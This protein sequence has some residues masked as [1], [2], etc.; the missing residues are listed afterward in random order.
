MKKNLLIKLLLIFGLFMVAEFQQLSAVRLEMRWDGDFLIEYKED[1]GSPA[2][3][4]SFFDKESFL[5][6]VNIDSLSGHWVL[7]R[8]IFESLEFLKFPCIEKAAILDCSNMRLGKLDWKAL[9]NLLLTLTRRQL[10]PDLTINIS[11]NDF[12]VG[13]VYLLEIIV[14]WLR[15]FAVPFSLNISGNCLMSLRNDVISQFFKDLNVKTQ[16]KKLIWH[17]KNE[18]LAR[19]QKRQNFF[20]AMGMMNF[21]VDLGRECAEELF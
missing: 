16:L 6:K 20:Y 3:T 17:E 7:R 21:S 14:A 2:V 5:S 12:G 18:S 4:I 15:K 8:K 19:V 10:P 9:D 11:N 13:D 1:D